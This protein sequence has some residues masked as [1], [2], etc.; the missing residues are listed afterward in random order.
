MLLYDKFI[1]K[2]AEVMWNELLF[3]I[4]GYINSAFDVDLEFFFFV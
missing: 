4:Y 1:D 2:Q 3:T